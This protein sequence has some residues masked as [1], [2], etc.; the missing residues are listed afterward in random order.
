MRWSVAVTLAVGSTSAAAQEPAPAGPAPQAG[1][2]AP[3]QGPLG[4]GFLFSSVALVGTVT[5]ATLSPRQNPGYYGGPSLSMGALATLPSRLVLGVSGDL[6]SGVGAPSVFLRGDA[7]IEVAYALPVSASHGPR[8]GV[9]LHADTF[10]LPG[11]GAGWTEL[12]APRAQLGYGIDGPVGVE[13]FVYGGLV[14][15]AG[16]VASGDHETTFAPSCGARVLV[17]GGGARVQVDARHVFSSDDSAG[18]AVDEVVGVACLPA[19]G[20]LQLCARGSFYQT[21][22]ATS[23]GRREGQIQVWSLQAGFGRQVQR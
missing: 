16:S 19:W 23:D 1:P 2:E 11:A 5:G 13:A 17:Y 8:A 9:G 12:E 21:P 4:R 15:G 22:A 6:V 10:Q 14:V 7:D 18:M 20:L 3:A